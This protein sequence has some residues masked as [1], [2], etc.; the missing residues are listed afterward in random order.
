[1]GLELEV[2]TKNALPVNFSCRCSL[3]RVLGAL[4]TL[5]EQE[6]KE[7]I[8]QD[9][10]AEVVCHWCNERYWIEAEK[11]QKLSERMLL[12]IF[13]KQLLVRNAFGFWYF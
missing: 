2:L 4:Q 10:G 6:R 12:I 11:L 13:K 5:T 9:D 7:M 1:M 8:E 3:E